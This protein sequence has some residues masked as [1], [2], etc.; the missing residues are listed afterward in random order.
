MSGIPEIGVPAIEPITLEKIEIIPASN[1]IKAE[2]KN[3]VVHGAGN[4]QLTKLK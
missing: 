2:L 1:G 4:F 3:V